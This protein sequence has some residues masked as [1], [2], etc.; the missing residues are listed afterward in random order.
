MKYIEGDLIELFEQGEFDVLVHGCNCR[1][2]MKSGI[3]AQIVEKYPPVNDADLLSNDNAEEKL[4]S[5]ECV[6]ISEKDCKSI[7]NAY[8]QL[9]Y[10]RDKNIVYVSYPAVRSV[11]RAITSYALNFQ[12]AYGYKYRFGIPKI[13]CGLANGDWDIVSRIIEEET[14][15]LDITVVEYKK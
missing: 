4:G 6:V 2:K 12:K 5:F 3:A 1:K 9:N 14:I 7:I 15:G 11:F 10:G 8:T 13:G